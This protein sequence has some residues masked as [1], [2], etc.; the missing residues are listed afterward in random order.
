MMT[1][2][3]DMGGFEEMVERFSRPMLAMAYRYTFDW[4]GAGDICQDTWMKVF[5]KMYKYD[6]RVP[7]ERWLFAVHR[8]I[9]LGFLRQ[10]KR[11]REIS[12]D[13]RGMIVDRLVSGDAGPDDLAS[14]SMMRERILEEASALPERQ[15]TVF[16]MID[17]EQM[18]IGE[19]AGVLGIKPVSVRTNLFH[20]RRRIAEGLGRSE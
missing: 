10:R 19:A 17:L 7:F 11:R 4:D 2:N 14:L 1:G 5:E 16:A 18:T 8:N 12:A 6:G 15:R 9:C 3:L 20:A 13:E